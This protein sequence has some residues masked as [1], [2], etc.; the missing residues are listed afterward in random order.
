MAVSRAFPCLLYYHPN[1][2]PSRLGECA[3][4]KRPAD[5]MRRL[6][7]FAVRSFPY[8][9]PAHPLLWINATRVKSVHHKKMKQIKKAQLPARAVQTQPA[10][11]RPVA[12]GAPIK[13]ATVAAAWPAG[14]SAIALAVNVCQ[15]HDVQLDLALQLPKKIV[16][17]TA[18]CD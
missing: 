4:H 15:R 3:A 6:F 5:A 12:A 1:P 11:D 2:R 16:R 8:S 9:L 18:F 10:T 17:P 14:V 13:L 7:H